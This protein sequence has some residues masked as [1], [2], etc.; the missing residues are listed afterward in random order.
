MLNAFTVD[1]ELRYQSIAYRWARNLENYDAAEPKRFVAYNNAMSANREEW[2][3]ELA[4]H[5]QLFFTLFGRLPKEMVSVLVGGSTSWDRTSSPRFSVLFEV[6]TF[7]DAEIL[8][9]CSSTTTV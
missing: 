8:T 7:V 4:S 2:V 6:I 1:V 5:D 9:L 3:Q